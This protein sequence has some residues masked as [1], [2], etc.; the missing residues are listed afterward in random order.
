MRRVNAVQGRESI[1]IEFADAIGVITASFMAC[2]PCPL[3]LPH[4]SPLNRSDKVIK[5]VFHI[6]PSWKSSRDS[7]AFA[8]IVFSETELALRQPNDGSSR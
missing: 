2:H 4:L 7:A 8:Q 5:H 3:V 1:P 6:P